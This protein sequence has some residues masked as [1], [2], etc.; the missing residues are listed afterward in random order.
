MGEGAAST[1]PSSIQ[2]LTHTHHRQPAPSPPSSLNDVTSQASVLPL[3]RS[4]G[5]WRGGSNRPEPDP[6]PLSSCS[7]AR[8]RVAGG[9]LVPV[10][11]VC[12][13]EVL[14]VSCLLSPCWWSVGSGFC[15]CGTEVPGP[16]LA[17]SQGPAL[18]S[19]GL[20]LSLPVGPCLGAGSSLSSPHTW[21]LWLPIQPG[22]SSASNR[23]KPFSALT[24]HGTGPD[25]L[26]QPRLG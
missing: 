7:P 26:S 6:G 20:S 11:W 2:V 18:A 19:R 25:P 17:G 23:R 10:G 16:W 1:A 5:L 14:H 13:L 24:A 3:A 9:G 22:L 4:L 8:L 21:K 12:F 15:D